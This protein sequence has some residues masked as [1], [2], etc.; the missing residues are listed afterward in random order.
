MI[1]ARRRAQISSSVDRV[2]SWV[3]SSL[4]WSGKALWVISTSALLLGVPWALAYA[5]D[6]QMAE[7]EGQM[8]MQ[9][10]ASEVSLDLNMEEGGDLDGRKISIGKRLI[11]FVVLDTWCSAWW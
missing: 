10:K 3:G 4:T 2:S 11:R 7:I 8:A 9:Q 5:D 6:Q 1:P